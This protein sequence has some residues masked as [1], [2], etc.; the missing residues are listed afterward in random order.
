[1]LKSRH[2]SLDPRNLRRSFEARVPAKALRDLG[3]WIRFGPEAP[4]SDEC[5][6]VDPNQVLGHYKPDPARGAP[7]LRRAQSGMV[8]SGD[9][10]LSHHTVGQSIKYQACLARFR[11]GVPWKQTGLYEEMLIRIGRDGVA[12]GCRNLDDIERRYA[13]LDALAEETRALGRFKTRAE[14]GQK[15]F[16]REH[17]GVL[18]H[19]GRNGEVIRAGGGQHRFAIAVALELPEMPV[20]LGVI[21]R[22][23][24]DLGVLRDLRQSRFS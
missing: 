16:R 23:A 1:M 18:V 7:K 21:H 13:A 10:D 14:L 6:Y 11:D 24:V 5:I 2:P 8:R 20:Q 15:Y 22:Q 3:N 12:D 4:L 9:W 19:I 17:G